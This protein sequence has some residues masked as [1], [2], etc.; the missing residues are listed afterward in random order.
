M[1]QLVLGG[2]VVQVGPICVCMTQEFGED[3]CLASNSQDHLVHLQLHLPLQISY[4]IYNNTVY[5]LLL[6][7]ATLTHI[8]CASLTYSLD[9]YK[10]LEYHT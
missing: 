5:I 3:T 8:S 6:H 2:L 10:W 1:R 4:P 9:D 7:K